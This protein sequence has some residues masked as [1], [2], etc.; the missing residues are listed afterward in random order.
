MVFILLAAKTAGKRLG[1]IIVQ[2]AWDVMPV[3]GGTSSNDK[4]AQQAT[5]RVLRNE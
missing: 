4:N 1:F 3:S 2:E 5:A